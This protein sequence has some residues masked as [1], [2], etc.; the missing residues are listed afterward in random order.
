M[1][2][3][4]G[5]GL[6]K[7]TYCGKHLDKLGG[8][9]KR[10]LK[11]LVMYFLFDALSSGKLDDYAAWVKYRRIFQA[12]LED[13]E[14]G[15]FLEVYGYRATD[16]ARSDP[17]L[18]RMDPDKLWT[19]AWGAA[20]KL[21]HGQEV[22]EFTDLSSYQR[23]GR[24]TF[25]VLAFQPIPGGLRNKYG[26]YTKRVD[27]VDV[28]SISDPRR[29]K[30]TWAQGDVEYTA[31]VELSPGAHGTASRALGFTG[32]SGNGLILLDFSLVR[33]DVREI[34]GAYMSYFKSLGFQFA[35]RTPVADVPSFV[36]KTIT[37]GNIDFLI[38]DGH[39]DG[40]D[41][42]VMVLYSSGFIM[43]GQ[44]LENGRAVA[45][46]IVFNLQDD[47]DEKR[48]SYADFAAQMDRRFTTMQTPLVYIDGSCWGIEKAWFGLGYVPS[49]QMV[50]IAAN[51]S[52]NYLENNENNAMRVLL[53][54]VIK[55]DTF[56]TLRARLS[57][58][59]GFASGQEDRFVFPDDALYPHSGPLLKVDRHL[60]SQRRGERPKPYTPDGYL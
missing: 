48:I 16:Q 23:D 41:D 43:K 56:D 34:L 46:N 15:E 54:G 27:D 4:F 39:S 37:E 40:D 55:G 53:D 18:S 9:L 59:D 31:T 30:W 32:S 52:V 21:F 42:N 24:I 6:L 25:N 60:S 49:S 57:G 51:T 44:R 26:F 35:G 50:E 8:D 17:E 10:K 3:S 38:R 14:T 12:F 19:F 29:F 2:E 1:Y 11:P 13:Q 7:N 45:V 20:A 33:E 58:L 5:Q 47:T 36:K 28:R 22:I